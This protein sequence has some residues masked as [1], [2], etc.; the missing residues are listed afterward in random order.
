[1]KDSAGQRRLTNTNEKRRVGKKKKKKELK[2]TK[3][4]SL[5]MMFVPIV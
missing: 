1:M 2:E 3:E 5:Y 4:G